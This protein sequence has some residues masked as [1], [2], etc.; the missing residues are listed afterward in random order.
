MNASKLQ[1]DLIE[2]GSLTNWSPQIGD[3]IFKDGGLFRW[4]ALV[5]GINGDNIHIMKSGNPTL[6]ITGDYKS[7]IVNAA[8][9][10]HSRLGSYFI[11]SRGIYY[12]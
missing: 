11:V 3:M 12:V 1:V 5:D 7:E 8:K 10:R 9:I 6:L 4:C 2:H